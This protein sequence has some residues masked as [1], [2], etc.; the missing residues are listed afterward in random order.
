MATQTVG[1]GDAN[2]RIAP[3]AQKHRSVEIVQ[4]TLTRLHSGRSADA[5]AG[6][7]A[8]KQIRFHGAEG[9][10]WVSLRSTHPTG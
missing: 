1:A 10:R 2:V 8:V 5:L 4:S 6:A 9:K 3:V 7:R